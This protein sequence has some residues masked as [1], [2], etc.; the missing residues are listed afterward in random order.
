VSPQRT[1]AIAGLWGAALTVVILAMSVLMRLGT[2]IDGGEAAS[3][4]LPGVETA[5]RAAHRVAA[6]AVGAIAAW[7]LVTGWRMRPLAGGSARALWTIGALTLLLAAIG[8]YTP[9]YRFDG[10]TMANVVGGIGLAAAFWWLRAGADGA[11]RGDGLAAVALALLL[12]LAAL[13]AGADVA[14]MR[15]ERAFGPVHLWL[16]S[17]F[18]VV[19]LAAAWRQRR[20]RAAMVVAALCAAQFVLGFL[21]VGGR[22]MA[23]AWAHALLA[24]GLALALV[25]LGARR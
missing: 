20:R 11:P 24:C 3:V 9:G 13:G 18:T 2:R 7:A 23:L 25:Q 17:F 6:M 4:L 1:L 12:A 14:A 16:A 10:V 22:P 8:R 15:G 21:L 19:A 5:A